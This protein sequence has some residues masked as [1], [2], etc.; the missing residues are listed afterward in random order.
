MAALMQPHMVLI[1]ALRKM[2][3]VSEVGF[4]YFSGGFLLT[5]NSVT[6]LFDYALY[7]C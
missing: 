1:T 7:N 2:T 4:N 6:N 5:I 3:F